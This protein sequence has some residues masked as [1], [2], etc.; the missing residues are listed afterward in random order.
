M[1]GPSP[2]YCCSGKARRPYVCVFELHVT[3]NC[4]M[5]AVQKC[6]RDTFTSPAAMQIMGP[7]FSNKLYSN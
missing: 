1:V 6:L 5:S 2:N 4:S 3:V 7:S